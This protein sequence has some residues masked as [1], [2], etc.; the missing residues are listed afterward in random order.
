MPAMKCVSVCAVERKAAQ[1]ANN[2]NPSADL[3]GNR[4]SPQA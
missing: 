2:K 4:P 1:A 3:R